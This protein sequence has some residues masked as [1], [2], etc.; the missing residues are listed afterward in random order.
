MHCGALKHAVTLAGY[1]GVR[2]C[3]AGTRRCT[4][5]ALKVSRY[6]HCLANCC[7]YVWRS[8]TIAAPA[9]SGFR[10]RLAVVGKLRCSQARCG[11][12]RLLWYSLARCWCSRPYCGARTLLWYWQGPV[13]RCANTW[14]SHAVV[15]LEGSASFAVWWSQAHCSALGHAVALAGSSCVQRH[16]S[17][18]RRHSVALAGNLVNCRVQ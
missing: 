13:Y 3:N 11:V 1:C 4:A 5:I 8:Q 7:A 2:R 6:W 10:R 18:A 17:G 15:V 14:Y 12:R 9:G 16:S